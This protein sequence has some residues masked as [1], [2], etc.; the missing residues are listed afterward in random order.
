MS[1]VIKLVE[2]FGLR[3]DLDQ[4]DYLPIQQPFALE[5]LVT[6]LLSKQTNFQKNMI[7]NTI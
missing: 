3:F 6:L 7:E 2:L 1:K 4:N 5:V